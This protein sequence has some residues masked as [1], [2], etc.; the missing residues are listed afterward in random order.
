MQ[1]DDKEVPSQNIADT[2]FQAKDVENAYKQR[3]W[4][5]DRAKAASTVFASALKESQ[6]S[7]SGPI[8]ET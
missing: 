4:M 7:S 5:L 8:Q 3:T 6:P 2:Q 1:I